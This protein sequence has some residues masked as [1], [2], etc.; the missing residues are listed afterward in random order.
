MLVRRDEVSRTIAS[1]AVINARG[2]RA[3]NARISK[4]ASRFCFRAF[5]LTIVN[6]ETDEKSIG[7]SRFVPERR[8]ARCYQCESIIAIA[9]LAA[10]RGLAR[11]RGRARALAL[12]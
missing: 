4:G 11:E 10:A 8:L 9:R 3:T 5:D 1:R 6:H 7:F 12:A 2:A